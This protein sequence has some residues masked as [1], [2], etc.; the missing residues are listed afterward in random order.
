MKKANRMPQKTKPNSSNLLHNKYHIAELTATQ[1]GK[2]K[3]ELRWIPTEQASQKARVEDIEKPGE[4]ECACNTCGENQNLCRSAE[5]RKWWSVT[6]SIEHIGKGTNKK[7]MPRN[8][9]RTAGKTDV[10]FLSHTYHI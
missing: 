2:I 1:S 6:N 10:I 4:K 8:N 3:V 5:E 7:Q 9:K